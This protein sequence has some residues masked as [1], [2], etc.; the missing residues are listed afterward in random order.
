MSRREKDGL[1]RFVKSVPS[2]K[3]AAF[4]KPGPLGVEKS[5]KGL[6]HNGDRCCR[7]VVESQNPLIADGFRQVCPVPPPT[8]HRTG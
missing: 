7:L 4:Q 5:L 8:S 2:V 3:R 1:D 6:S